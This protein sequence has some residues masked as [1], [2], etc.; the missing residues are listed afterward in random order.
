MKAEGR[1]EIRTG[2]YGSSHHGPGLL[3][4]EGIEVLGAGVEVGLG[5]GHLTGEF[6]SIPRGAQSQ[7]A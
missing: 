1:Q 2:A 7:W 6:S 5:I 3:L 4:R